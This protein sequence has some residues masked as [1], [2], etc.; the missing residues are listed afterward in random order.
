MSAALHLAKAEDRDALLPLVA[1]FHEEEQIATEAE[2]RDATVLPL[3]EGSP[4]GCIYIIGPRKAPI[5]YI[6]V[7]FSWSVSFGGMNALIDEFY[8]RPGVRKRG[9]GSEVLSAL[10][11]QLE[12]AGVQAIHLDAAADR[13]WLQRLYRRAG[14]RVRDGFHSMTRMAG[15]RMRDG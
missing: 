11:P 3:L 12:A 9:V 7:T 8:V 1:A 4:F 10:L 14:F 13:P 6:T 5:G 15:S 2:E